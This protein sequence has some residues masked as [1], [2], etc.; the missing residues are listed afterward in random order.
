MV[1]IVSDLVGYEHYFVRSQ[2][3]WANLQL[4]CANFMLTKTVISCLDGRRLVWFSDEDVQKGYAVT[5]IALTMH[6]I[7]RDVEAYPEPCIY[8]QVDI[9]ELSV[10]VCR[11]QRVYL[12][13][14]KGRCLIRIW[15]I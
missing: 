3:L 5:F 2:N 11:L 7:S 12:N 4:V 15:K 1:V 13:V 9:S 14:L 10:Q 6:A 8:T